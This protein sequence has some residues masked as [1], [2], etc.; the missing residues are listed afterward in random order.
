MYK[1]SS[2]FVPE[3]VGKTDKIPSKHIGKTD[4]MPSK[5]VGKTDK[6]KNLV[7]LK[8]TLIAC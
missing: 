3:N 4:K 2:T 5:Y 1:K 8:D 6:T 7:C